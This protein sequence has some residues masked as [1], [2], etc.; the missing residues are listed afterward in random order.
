MFLKNV[1]PVQLDAQHVVYLTYKSYAY[2]VIQLMDIILTLLE[3][4]LA[5]N[6]SLIV[7]LM[8]RL[9]NVLLV[10]QINI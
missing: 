10:C 6:Q 3:E 1:L 8:L 2:H 9:I 5:R 4:H 7:L